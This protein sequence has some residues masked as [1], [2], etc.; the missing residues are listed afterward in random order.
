MPPSQKLINLVRGWPAPDL[1]PAHL[2]SSAAARVLAEP[3]SST[4][5]LQY[6]PSAGHEPLREGL[7]RWF[8]RHYHV[9]PDP[10]RIC[11]TGGASQN[12][13]NVL[14]SFTDPVCTRAVW[15]VAP[16]YHLAS[17]IFDDAGFRGRLRA[18]PEDDEG[19][20]LQALEDKIQELEKSE[21]SRPDEDRVSTQLKPHLPLGHITNEKLQPFK[22]PGPFRKFYRHVIY[23]VTTCA[24]PSGKTMSLRRRQGLVTLARKYDCL[25]ISD[26]VYD[27]LQWPLDGSRPERERPPALRVPRLCDVDRATTSDPSGFG[28]AVS[29]G[30]FSKI[31]GPGVRTGW[32]EGSPAFVEGLGNTGS[33]LSGGAPSALAAG[34]LGDMVLTG[35][36]EDFI[37]EKTRPALQ[38][39]HGLM[40]D[41]IKEHL[42]PMAGEMRRSSLL[43]EGVY[44]G[45]FVWFTPT[46][47]FPSKLI[48][49]V[50]LKEENLI[51]GYGN[52]FEVHGDEESLQ[53]NKEIRLCFSWEPEQDMVEG[54]RRLG[55][56]LEKMQENKSGYE[57]LSGRAA[58]RGF[59][60]EYK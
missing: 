21:A 1:L 6:G 22:D 51:I 17:A 19:I 24:N 3:S 50:A 9:D 12:L 45:Y 28:N 36:L 5:I 16:C 44:G 37:E 2:L 35:Q 49:D 7:A 57:N 14:Q 39:R 48:A 10:A 60:N 34:I 11:I 33:T 29:N 59:V 46:G 18:T 26:D 53:F 42:G 31:A 20:D 54:V 15:L 41:A 47:G 32:L 56:V 52:M 25:V 55:K 27:F 40:M 4:P 58:D 8:G 43:N 13:A 23:T 38:R 30:S